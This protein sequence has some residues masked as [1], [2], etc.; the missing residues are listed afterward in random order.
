M[1]IKVGVVQHRRGGLFVVQINMQQIDRALVFGFLDF[2]AGIGLDDAQP[3]VI[4][5]QLEPQMAGGDDL[6]VD[7]DGGGFHAQLFVA[8]LGQRSR[9]QPELHGVLLGHRFGVKKQ[10]AR[11][12]ALHIFELDVIRRVAQH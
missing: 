10:Q 3:H 1:G 6:R 8:K 4:A 2:C 11:H 9:P 7:L 12:H 5:R